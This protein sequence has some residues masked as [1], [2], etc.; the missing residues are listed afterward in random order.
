[1]TAY[2][3]AISPYVT[4]IMHSLIINITYLHVHLA[5]NF[6]QV[7]LLYKC[8]SV[9]YNNECIISVIPCFLTFYSIAVY[10]SFITNFI[11]IK[12][13]YL[14]CDDC[15]TNKTTHAVQRKVQVN[16]NILY[17]KVGGK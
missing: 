4:D 9:I 14:N 15:N 17:E 6:G 8:R 7:N 10:K 11:F 2:V 16:K 3:W 5:Q 1:M 12:F 13:L